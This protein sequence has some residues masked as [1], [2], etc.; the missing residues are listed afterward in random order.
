MNKNG[1]PFN[2]P[3]QRSA[4]MN[5]IYTNIKQMAMGYSIEGGELYKNKE[6][7]NDIIYSLDYMHDNYYTKRYQKIF[8]GFDNWWNWDIGIPQALVQILVFLKDELTIDQINKYLSPL[9]KYIPLPSMTMANRIDIAYSCIIAGA[10]QK[11]YKRIAFSIEMLRICFNNVENGD[12]FYDDGSFIQH[13]VF[14]YIGGYGSALINAFS[15]ITFS[16]EDTCF[17]FDDKMKEEQYNW[18]INSF[19]PFLYDGAFFD[20]VRGR[21]VVRKIKGQSTGL[22]VIN[23]LFFV[24]KYLK[25]EKNLCFL[26]NY[27]KKL[28]FKYQKFY[29]NSLSIGVLSILEEIIS[30]KIFNNLDTKTNFAKVY[31]RMDKAIS[32]INGIAIGISLSSARTGKYESINEENKKGWYQGDGMTYIYLS[33]DDYANL[34]WPYVNLLRLPGTT[35]TK[36]QREP[37]SLSGKKALAKYDFVGGTYS[38]ENM[39]L[40]MQFASDTPGANFSSSLIGNKAYFIFENIL[41][42]IGNK[43]YCSDDYGVETIIENRKI[44][45]KLFFGERE[46]NEKS[47]NVTS[48]YIYIE[49]YGGIYIPDYKN[50]LFNITNNNFLELYIEHGIKIKNELYKY[51]ILPKIDKNNFEKII[52]N[53]HIISDNNIVTAILNK[54]NNIIEYVF[55]E[56]GKLG[57]LVVDNPCTIILNNNEIYISDP[58]QKLDY[59]NLSFG[60]DKFKVNLY[61]GYTKKINLIENKK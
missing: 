36:S 20:L 52:N 22:A 59:I 45:K 18:I 13:T 57:E 2:S 33:P 30:D 60:K 12:G 5:N 17:R 38:N 15:R 49:D 24:S 10:L 46:I 29:D 32:Q 9:N 6:L 19:I 16:L 28:Y 43:I 4:D 37:S 58:T 14:A 21:G 1:L 25:N 51:F 3:M 27:L 23:S 7:F 53:F 26:K 41:I 47:G 56:K 54:N 44:N 50:V 48:N 39:V 40:A 35:V 11:D 61:K 34:Y 8:S 55:W 31:S 42:C